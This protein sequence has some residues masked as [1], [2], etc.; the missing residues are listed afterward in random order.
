MSKPVSKHAYAQRCTRLRKALAEET[1]SGIWLRSQIDNLR[2]RDRED[3][4]V[5]RA[6]EAGAR[7]ALAAEQSLCRR[8]KGLAL[9][10][11]FGWVS[12]CGLLVWTT[13]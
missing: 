12:C 1:E 7:C 6:A 4:T 10:A 13:W 2:H 5:L 9:A 3:N 8:W 11:L